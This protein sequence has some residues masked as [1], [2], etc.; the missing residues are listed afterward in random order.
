M[1]TYELPIHPGPGAPVPASPEV[2]WYA[3]RAWGYAPPEAMTPA[4]HVVEALCGRQMWLLYVGITT[5][6]G[7]DRWDEH[8]GFGEGQYRRP[9]KAWAPYVKVIELDDSR[10]FALKTDAEA[11]EATLIDREQP[12][13][14]TAGKGR[15]GSRYRG[16][17][18]RRIRY[19]TLTARAR[20]IRLAAPV[21]VYGYLLLSL[22]RLLT[23]AFPRSGLEWG[24]WAAMVAVLMVAARYGAA[25]HLMGARST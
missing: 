6:S 14:N 22:P 24:A 21:V 15:Q 13:G 19:L 17:P 12:L 5:R 3:Y 11:W 25:R 16:R 18:P 20:R 7:P 9:P 10:G 8:L 4:M 23:G 2:I 1:T